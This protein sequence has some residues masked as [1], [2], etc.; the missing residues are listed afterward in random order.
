[1]SLGAENFAFLRAMVRKEI[2]IV[3]DADRDYVA[4]ARLSRLAAQEGFGSVEELIEDY[5]ARPVPLH[6]KVLDAMT[7]N[8]TWFFRDLQQFE[9]IRDVMLPHVIAARS[10]RRRLVL[11]SA[12]CST[13]QEPYSLA[14]LLRQHFPALLSWD[15]HIFATDYSSVALAKA[16]SGLYSQLEIERGS[17]GA[18]LSRFFSRNGPHWLIAPEIRRMVRFR[19]I[20]LTRPWRAAPFADLILLR[21]VLIYFDDPTRMAVVRAAREHLADDGYLL[22]GAAESILDVDSGLRMEQINKTCCYRRR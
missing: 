21:N 5:R 11:W 15:V 13:G 7:N 12:A 17:P 22:V 10:P 16:E 3:V 6:E 14:M 4:E 19:Q 2:G 20:N 8:E 1:M 18:M 9:A